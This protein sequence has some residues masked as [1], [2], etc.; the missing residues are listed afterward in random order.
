M[1]MVQKMTVMVSLVGMTAGLAACGDGGSGPE[2]SAA[3]GTIIVTAETWAKNDTTGSETKE[4]PAIKGE[5]YAIKGMTT[6]QVLEV[7][8][9]SDDSVTFT[10]EGAYFTS[11][12]M[13][14]NPEFTLEEG[15]SVAFNTASADAGIRY[16]INLEVVE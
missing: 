15:E 1:K 16:E 5:S 6:T 10:L 8:D 4:L 12:G 11:D 9:V 2:S 13:S 7:T 3:E 14:D